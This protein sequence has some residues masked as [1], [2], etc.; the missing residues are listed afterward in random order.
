MELICHC[1][2][3][4]NAQIIKSITSFNVSGNNEID[5]NGWMNFFTFICK[6]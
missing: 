3:D 6:C 4:M 2:L 1:L 5:D